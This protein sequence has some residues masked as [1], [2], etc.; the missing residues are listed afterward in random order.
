MQ[1]AAGQAGGSNIFP[2]AMPQAIRATI[3]TTTSG[4][5]SSQ[6][7]MAGIGSSL[8]CCVARIGTAPV[9]GRTD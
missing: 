3:S 4:A 7:M 6:A 5:P 9:S 8:S 1:R 2:G